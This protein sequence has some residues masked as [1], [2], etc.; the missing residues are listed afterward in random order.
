M[1]KVPNTK[2]ETVTVG[3]MQWNVLYVSWF[4]ARYTLCSQRPDIRVY[5]CIRSSCDS[6]GNIIW[7]YTKKSPARFLSWQ[8]FLSV[9]CITNILLDRAYEYKVL[10]SPLPPT[11]K[12]LLA[13][14]SV[15]YYGKHLLP[16]SILSH[17]R[18]CEW[19][20]GK[21]RSGC[22]MGGFCFSIL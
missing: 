18:R 19:A 1:S 2:A 5:R 22:V 21:R 10:C 4:W 8:Y 12:F 3:P 11:G 6:R 13:D 17:K 20:G 9:S 16:S 15:H 7:M 14:P